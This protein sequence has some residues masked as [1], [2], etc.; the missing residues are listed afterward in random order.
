MDKL[1]EAGMVF[2]QAVLRYADHGVDAVVQEKLVHI[3]KLEG[4][5]DALRRDLERVLL[6]E[7]L[8][9][10]ARGDVLSLLD[11]LDDLL[12]DLKHG[13][14]T[15]TIEQPDFPESLRDDLKDLTTTVVKS[16]EETAV[17]S[18]AYFRDPNAVPDH[19]HK[20]GFHEKEADTVALRMVRAIFASTMP[21]ERKRH[22]QSCV[23]RIDGLADG[24]EDVGDKLGIYAVK[25]SL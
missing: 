16:I 19:I 2:E 3:G 17:A 21:L 1:S 25:R 6:T 24:A 9:P 18:R 11:N 7:M 23:A 15:L 10:D 14:Q 5:G 4:R 12:D 22:L 13:L 8:I 20:I